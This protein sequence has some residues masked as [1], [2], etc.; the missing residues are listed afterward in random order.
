MDLS[1]CVPLVNRI[2]DMINAPNL[3]AIFKPQGLPSLF[4]EISEFLKDHNK[5]VLRI[6]LSNLPFEH[7]TREIIGN[8][9]GRHLLEI[10]RK[11]KLSK[12]P[13]VLIL[14]EAHQFLNQQIREQNEHFPLD[15]FGLIAKEGRKYSLTIVISTQRPR[16]I[17]EDVLSQVGIFL[18]HR[19]TND[20][21]LTVVERAAGTISKETMSVLPNL[22]PGESI[23]LG[24]SIEQPILLKMHAPVH[25]P[26]SK[27]P[28]YQLYWRGA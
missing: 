19:L 17:P 11:G 13:V 7:N 12:R 15:S 4:E 2:Q 21:D 6:S 23:L 16:D 22:I 20:Y 9:I 5:K 27:G 14:D 3:K 8:A 24:V 10:G 26:L 25:P 28:D 18:I 1:Y